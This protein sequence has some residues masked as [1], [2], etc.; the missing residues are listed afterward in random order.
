MPV[1]TRT[2]LNGFRILRD[3]KPRKLGHAD[4]VLHM[5]GC[6]IQLSKT[7]LALVCLLYKQVGQG[8]HMVAFA[9]SLARTASVGRGFICLHLGKCVHE[10]ERMLLCTSRTSAG[11]AA[12]TPGESD[13][14]S[15]CGIDCYIAGVRHSAFCR[16]NGFVSRPLHVL[17]PSTIGKPR[18]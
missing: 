8:F 10:G 16:T 14:C 3:P 1:R 11:N 12:R 9:E 7:E 18:S 17:K 15:N 5:D 13:D 2:R 4:S 6:Y